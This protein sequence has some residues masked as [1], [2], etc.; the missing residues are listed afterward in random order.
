MDRSKTKPAKKVQ[1]RKQPK[2]FCQNPS[3]RFAQQTQL[4][5]VGCCLSFATSLSSIAFGIRFSNLTHRGIITNGPYRYT[6]HPAYIS[7]NLSWWLIA[8]PFI[9]VNDNDTASQQACLMLFGMNAIYYMR[10]KNRRK[11][12]GLGRYLPTVCTSH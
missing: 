7:K 11:A 2:P 6:R 12:F 9:V 8:I 10:A 4:R 1:W 5:V 3:P